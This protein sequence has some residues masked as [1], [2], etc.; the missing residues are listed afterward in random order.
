MRANSREGTS[1]AYYAR[2][3]PAPTMVRC[4]GPSFVSWIRATD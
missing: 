2:V 4:P 1:A 3:P